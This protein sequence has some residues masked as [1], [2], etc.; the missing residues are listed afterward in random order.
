MEKKN[1]DNNFEGKERVVKHI[2]K[3]SFVVFVS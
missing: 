2:D 1:E 3:H